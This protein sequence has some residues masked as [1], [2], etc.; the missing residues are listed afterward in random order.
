MMRRLLV[1]LSCFALVGCAANYTHA[2][3]HQP[4]ETRMSESIWLES[5]P[6]TAKTVYVDFNNTSSLSGFYIRNQVLSHLKKEGYTLEPNPQYAHYL[7]DVDVMKVLYVSED[8][9]LDIGKSPYGTP[10]DTVPLANKRG[11][12][13]GVADIKLVVR[14]VYAKGGRTV[15]NSRLVALPVKQKLSLDDSQPI[16]AYAMTQKINQ[17][18]SDQDAT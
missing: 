15:Y 5:V 4:A 13:T 12:Y 8:I 1:G 10:L 6:H 18:F 14:N 16:I 2:Q 3:T 11:F 7:L 17:I 9:A